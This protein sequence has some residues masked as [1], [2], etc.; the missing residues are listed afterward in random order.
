MLDPINALA[1]S[2]HANKGVY[3]VLLGSGISRAAGIPTGWEITLELVRKLAAVQGE[4]CEP[5]PAAWYRAKSGRPP[6]YAELLD[7]VA[8][9]PAERQQLLRSYWEPTEE[10]REA[11]SKLPTP[12]HHAV[13]RLVRDGYVR[14]IVTTNFDKLMELALHAAG[15]QPAVLS[16]VDHIDGAV[17]LAHAP[18]TVIKVHGDYLDTRMFNTPQELASY[19]AAMNRLLD[20]VFDEYGL[21][22]CG[23]SADWDLALRA[24]IERQPARRYAG[25]WASRS[26]P[27]AAAATLIARRAF[28]TVPITDADSFVVAAADQVQALADFERPH[29]MSTAAAVSV[30]KRYLSEPK[31]AIQLHDLVHAEVDR[32]LSACAGAGFDMHATA[33]QEPEVVPR[34]VRYEAA[35]ETLVRMGYHAGYWSSDEQAQPWLD[36]AARLAQRRTEGGFEPWVGLQRYPATL[37]LYAFGLG[38]VVARRY[39]RLAA[40]LQVPVFAAQGAAAPVVDLLPPSLLFRA[41]T[42]QPLRLPGLPNWLASLSDRIATVLRS[43]PGAALS[44]DER[45]EAAFDTLEV[46]IALN[47]V[48]VHSTESWSSAIPLGRLGY[49]K[50]H[51]KRIHHELQAAIGDGEYGSEPG[52]LAMSG[53]VGSRVESCRSN[54]FRLAS[55]VDQLQWT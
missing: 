41:D 11:G 9:T 38:A 47:S 6:D 2:L 31:Y 1:F 37:L 27:G 39:G 25:Y 44:A 35:C 36:A 23:W 32:A 7:L 4:D 3:A 12:A 53:L 19:P 33:E 42:W 22:V 16:T 17:P 13:A 49:R 50:A 46:L 34:L 8:K 18:C 51:F 29:P 28:Q 14:V 52:P 55:V 15:V 40:L 45:F 30:L 20:R 5:D 48:H 26:A 10:E 24:A 43:V 54:L 21:V